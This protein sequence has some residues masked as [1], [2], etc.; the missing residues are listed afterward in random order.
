MGQHVTGLSNEQIEIIRK[1]DLRRARSTSHT[2]TVALQT[3][4]SSILLARVSESLSLASLASF[5]KKTSTVIIHKRLL[6][7]TYAAIAAWVF[8]ALVVEGVEIGAE[9]VNVSQHNRHV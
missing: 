8:V 2:L 1:V 7:I 3:I 6:V 9:N 5:I 4:L